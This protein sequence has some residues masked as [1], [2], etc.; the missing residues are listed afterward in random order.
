MYVPPF[1]F[2]FQIVIQDSLRMRHMNVKTTPSFC[3]YSCSGEGG[4]HKVK[5][6]TKD[7]I[8]MLL[9]LF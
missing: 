7:Q 4:G 9:P 2:Q 3:A 8:W 5:Q 6:K 1:P